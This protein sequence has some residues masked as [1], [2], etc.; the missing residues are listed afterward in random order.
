MDGG[1]FITRVLD[2]EEPKAVLSWKEMNRLGYDAVALGEIELR[3]WS[4][5]ERL[6][7]EFPLPIVSTNIERL[8]DGRWVPV[9][10]KYRILDVDGVKV[11]VVSAVAEDLASPLMLRDYEDRLRILPM[12][13]ELTRTLEVLSPQVDVVVLLAHMDGRTLEQ[14]ASLI[15]NV[16]VVLGGHATQDDHMPIQVSEV[17][18]NRSGTRGQTLAT[19]RLI[20]SPEGQIVDFGGR[21]VTLE[22]TYKEDPQVLAAVEEV[23]R[24]TRPDT[25]QGPPPTAPPS[26]VGSRLKS[27][28]VTPRAVE[29][30]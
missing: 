13:E 2:R 17:I 29:K 6:I 15:Q 22:P 10:E 3:N 11:G 7:Q 9:G 12:M 28:Q 20:I 24:E 5:V 16:E 21:N 25:P 26:P 27:E 30:E 18:V 23:M 8:V 14:Q 19:T 4:L 1:D